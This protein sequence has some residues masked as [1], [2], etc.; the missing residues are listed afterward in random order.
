MELTK[1]ILLKIGFNCD[2]PDWSLC[3]FYLYNKQKPEYKINVSILYKA[4]SNKLQ[5]NVD[6]YLC[7]EKGNIIK[8]SS[9]T[10]VQ[11]I[12]ELQQIIN[13]CNIDFNI[14]IK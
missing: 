2:H 11:T 4:Y 1:D 14:N 9:L 6:C 3:N 5:F 8:Q 10:D 13:L 12:E 7:N